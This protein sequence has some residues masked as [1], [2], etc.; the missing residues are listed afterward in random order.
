[1]LCISSGTWEGEAVVVVLKRS[2]SRV[3]HCKVKCWNGGPWVCCLWFVA[4]FIFVMGG[5]DDVSSMM[6]QWEYYLGMKTQIHSLTFLDDNGQYERQAVLVGFCDMRIECRRNGRVILWLAI[7]VEEY[8]CMLP[9][10]LC[11]PPKSN[12]ACCPSTLED[13]NIETTCAISSVLPL[14]VLR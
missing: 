5:D 12:L 4:G 13:G 6:R 14:N 9:K 2:V 8:R 7:Q 3:G 10:S 1:M 11:V